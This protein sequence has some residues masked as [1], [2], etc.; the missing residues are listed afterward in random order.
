MSSRLGI[1]YQM[2]QLI[3][4]VIYTLEKLNQWLASIATFM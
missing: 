2:A 1:H 4:Q 3:A